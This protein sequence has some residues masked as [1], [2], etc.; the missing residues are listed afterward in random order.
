M[1]VKSAIPSFGS[2]MAWLSP[3]SDAGRFPNS[4]DGEGRLGDEDMVAIGPKGGV[5]GIIDRDGEDETK[6][7]LP[8]ALMAQRVMRPTSGS[9]VSF[10]VPASIQ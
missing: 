9:R 1:L 7:G 3:T 4:R 5:I 6:I 8:V 2:E 10:A